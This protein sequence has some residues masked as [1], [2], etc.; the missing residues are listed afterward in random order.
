[1]LTHLKKGYFQF[2]FPMQCHPSIP[3]RLVGWA[4][5]L[6]REDSFPAK[7]SIYATS[8]YLAFMPRAITSYTIYILY[9][10]GIP[11]WAKTY[12][13]A[14]KSTDVRKILKIEDSAVEQGL[15]STFGFRYI[16]VHTIISIRAS[17]SDHHWHHLIVLLKKAIHRS[18]DASTAVDTLSQPCADGCSS[19][20]W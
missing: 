15:C 1:M 7:H 9:N 2:K 8:L 13:W 17:S 19:E 16:L 3:R 10:S 12:P 5:F 14:N 11:N 20:W 4:N 18:S 6:S